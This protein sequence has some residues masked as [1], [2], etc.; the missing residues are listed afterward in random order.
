MIKYLTRV[1]KKKNVLF[2]AKKKQVFSP[3]PE[4]MGFNV[5]CTYLKKKTPRLEWAHYIIH[6]N[7][8]GKLREQQ[9][10]K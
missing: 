3:F 2:T 5:L 9:G 10:G 6:R 1:K 8:K 4:H 7:L